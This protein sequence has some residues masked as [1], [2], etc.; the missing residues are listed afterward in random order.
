MEI[1]Y[2]S[3]YNYIL[4]N[5]KKENTEEIG[6]FDNLIETIPGVTSIN[7][8]TARLNLP[9]TCGDEKLIILPGIPDI[10]EIEDILA[11]FEN[12]VILKLSRNYKQFINFLKDSGYENK[13]AF[14]S[15]CNYTEEFITTDL[16]ELEEREI[17]YLSLMI[18]KNEIGEIHHM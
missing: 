7:A 11:D 1:P 5:I 13:F 8:S 17:D 15:K 14:I 9:L 18:L 2:F 4:K 10:K 6:P 3:T 12:V 16:A